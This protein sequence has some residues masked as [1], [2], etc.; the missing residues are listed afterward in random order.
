MHIKL[1]LIDFG[2]VIA[3]EGFQLGILR[4]ALKYD[5]PFRDMY[6]ICSRVAGLESGYTAGRIGEN[7][8]WKIVAGELGTSEDM[9]VYRDMFLDNFQPRRDMLKLVSSMRKY[10]KTGLFSDQTNWIHELDGMYSFF[11]C[12]DYKWISYDKGLTK[13]DAEFYQLPSHESG[14]EPQS[15]LLIDDKQ[16]VLDMAEAAGIAGHLFTS[17]NEC[18]D[19]LETLIDHETLNA[20]SVL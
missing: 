19:F 9:S 7:E 17:V 8:Y 1:L 4:L 5:I 10:V 11:S 2:G 20:G 14:I 12:F 16:R 13:Y 18:R 6:R 3:P 15:I